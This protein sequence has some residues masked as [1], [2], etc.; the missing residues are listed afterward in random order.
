LELLSFFSWALPGFG[1]IAFLVILILVLVISLQ[2]LRYGVAI[3]FA[4]LI[5]GSHGYLFSLNIEGLAISIRMG[6]F[7]ILLT[8]GLLEV[9]KKRRLAVWRSAFFVPLVVLAIMVVWSVIYGTM[10]GN[11]FSNVFFDV[12]SFLFF[13]I[14][15]PLWQAVKNKEDWMLLIRVGI[16]AVIASIMKVLFVLYVFSHEFWWMMPETYR[17]VRDLRIGEITLIQEP[18]YRIFFQSQI[19]TIFAFF[20]VLI[21]VAGYF[22][23][24][25]IK[26]VIK[27]K[28]FWRDFIFASLLFS[29]ILISFSRSNWVGIIIA[30]LA[31][32]IVYWISTSTIWKKIFSTY[33]SW[34]VLCLVSMGIVTT[35]VLFPFPKPSG[36]FNAGSL[37][38][39]RA[40]TFKGEAGVSSRWQLLPPLW[41]EIKENPVL[42]A[43]FGEEVTYVTKDPR[44]LA[45]NPTG[46]YTT[47]VFEWGYLDLWLKLGLV[48]LFVY[49]YFIFA[50]IRQS[51][52]VLRVYKKEGVSD[53]HVAMMQG[54]LLGGVAL[55]ATQTF[56]PYLNHPLGIGFLLLWA[57][58]VDLNRDLSD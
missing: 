9:Y 33:L 6:I 35:V 18:F 1:N 31:F 38:S 4:E 48:G 30:A 46:E 14:A 21:I 42:G 8:V 58:Y 39:K 15:I 37:L 3:A 20:I 49:A 45:Q 12:N 23:K 16:A 55:L 28:K 11:G 54:L 43:G 50:I 24:E 29:S 5:I 26:Q 22:Q 44:I 53:T 51:I 10:Q 57:L 56:S 19:Y 40:L 32:P 41:G 7:I 2:D 36:E 13:L 52:S 17:W 25:K 34:F 27:N 47:F